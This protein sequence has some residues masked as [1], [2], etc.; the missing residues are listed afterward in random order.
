[1]KTNTITTIVLAVTLCTACGESPKADSTQKSAVTAKKTRKAEKPT[2]TK[3]DNTAPEKDVDSPT[4]YKEA[5]K[6]EIKDV[7]A[8][9][10]VKVEEG[11]TVENF[12]VEGN[13]AVY[14]YMCEE[15]KVNIEAVEQAKTKMKERTRES[16]KTTDDPETIH[17]LRMLRG[18][19]M[20]L[21][22][23]YKGTKSGRAVDVAFSPEE[24]NFAQEQK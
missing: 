22:F 4:V 21:I 8:K 23:R 9:L 16:L 2:A 5:L 17:L 14:Y 6:A 10:P 15:P 20:G 19:E 13:D 11:V 3:T 18:G 12:T 24:L 7:C 1:M